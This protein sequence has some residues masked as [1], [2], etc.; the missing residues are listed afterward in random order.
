MK[1]YSKSELLR[2]LKDYDKT[3]DKD[4][5]DGVYLYAISN[6]VITRDEAINLYP[7]RVANYEL[8]AKRVEDALNASVEERLTSMDKK[9]R[10]FLKKYFSI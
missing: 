2:L 8:E 4:R 6:D 9:T 3:D 10:D 1:T 7:V 5:W